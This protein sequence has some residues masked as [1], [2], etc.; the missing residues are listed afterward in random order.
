[1][2][3]LKVGFIGLGLMGNPMAKNILK[4]G[5]PLSVYNRSSQKTKEFLKIGVNV[6]D[7]PA[8]MAKNS[9]VIIAMVTAGKDLEEVLF[10]RNGVVAGAKE[11]L[12]LIDMSTIGPTSARKISRKLSRNGIGFLDAPVTG[13]T[14]KAQSGELTIL[15]GGDKKVFEKVKGILKVLGTDISYIGPSSA[16]QAMKL[17]NNLMGGISVAAVAEGM[18]LADKLRLPRSQV[19]EVLG[20]VWVVSPNMKAKMQLMAQKKY[21]VAFSLANMRKDLKLT[22]DEIGKASNLRLL[23]ETEK[24]LKKGM[25]QGLAAEDYSAIEKII[26]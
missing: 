8:E 4:A 13:S 7:S 11:G 25:D 24:L 5:F 12:I 14:A 2:D 10:N 15:V 19:L 22:L 26:R 6:Y 23:R 3:K 16:G 18:V 9:D 20:D 1:M 17:V 21:P